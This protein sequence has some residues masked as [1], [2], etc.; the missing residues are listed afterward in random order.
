[1]IKGKTSTGFEFEIDEQTTIS[2]TGSAT[3]DRNYV[4]ITGDCT[5]TIS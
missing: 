2:A 3:V 5:I 4:F 1:M